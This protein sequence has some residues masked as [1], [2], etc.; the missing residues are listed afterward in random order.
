MSKS[1]LEVVGWRKST[2]GLDSRTGWKAHRTLKALLLARCSGGSWRG[3]RG[4]GC[5]LLS[6]VHAQ[7]FETVSGSTGAAV[8]VADRVG[9]AVNPLLERFAENSLAP[10]RKLSLDDRKLRPN[11]VLL[12]SLT[13]RLNPFLDLLHTALDGANGLRYLLGNEAVDHLAEL[14]HFLQQL[15]QLRVAIR[16]RRVGGCG[17][18]RGSLETAGQVLNLGVRFV[19]FS[20]ERTNA[21][22]RAALTVLKISNLR[23]GFGQLFFGRLVDGRIGVDFRGVWLRTGIGCRLFASRRVDQVFCCR[24]VGLNTA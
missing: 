24:I 5:T 13:K 14:G 9:L 1:T 23:S 3:R 12:C 4:C 8:G 18:G 16:C 20:L 7:E 10:L 15:R 21:F 17:G 11:G 19:D 6:A 22:R 2:G